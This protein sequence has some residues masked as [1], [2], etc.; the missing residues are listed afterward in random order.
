MTINFRPK[1]ISCFII[2][3]LSVFSILLFMNLSFA[4]SIIVHENGNI[5]IG[6][7]SP[8]SKLDVDG[9]IRGSGF[10]G[11]DKTSTFG[12]IV[13][14][15]T[16]NPGESGG[17]NSLN[18][19]GGNG[20]V[21]IMVASMHSSDEKGGHVYDIFLGAH[22]QTY[23]NYSASMMGIFS[24]SGLTLSRSGR[25]VTFSNNTNLSS[26]WILKQL[27]LTFFAETL[28]AGL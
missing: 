27:P 13:A 5:G 4:N 23:N 1:S 3:L 22:G 19:Y 26:K 9:E 16:L 12:T 21:Y 25:E 6:T 28:G 11:A 10:K 15:G 18:S 8:A 2:H 24:N 14:S 7:P 17:V 20:R